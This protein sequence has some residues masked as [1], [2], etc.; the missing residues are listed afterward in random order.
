MDFKL[1]NFICE[2]KT[3]EEISEIC[4]NASPQKSVRNVC[5]LRCNLVQS[6]GL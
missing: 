4:E 3:L 2:E 5:N 6:G 1:E